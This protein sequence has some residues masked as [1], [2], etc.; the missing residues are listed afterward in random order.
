MTS[1]PYEEEPDDHWAQEVADTFQWRPGP[2]GQWV[3]EGTCPFCHHK[4]FRAISDAVLVDDLRAAPGAGTATL[5]IL[6]S[7]NCRGEH[8]GCPEGKSG[9]GRY[10]GLKLEL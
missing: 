5:D 1:V 4:M 10:G 3:F 6:V 7:C 2:G 9:C 8:A